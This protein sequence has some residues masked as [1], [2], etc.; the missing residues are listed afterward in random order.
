MIDQSINHLFA[1]N[2]S[3]GKQH[4]H[5]DKYSIIK[6]V[7]E[8]SFLEVA[9]EETTAFLYILHHISVIEHLTQKSKQFRYR[10]VIFDSVIPIEIHL[11]F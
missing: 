7:F 1:H 9:I 5:Q 8:D 10:Y 11:V 2:T 3:N 6:T 4:E